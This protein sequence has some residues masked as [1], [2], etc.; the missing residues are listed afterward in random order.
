MTKYSLDSEEILNKISPITPKEKKKTQNWR[1]TEFI[2][3][4][5]N[6]IKSL[7]KEKKNIKKRLKKLSNK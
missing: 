4:I 3:F 7:Q 5:G 2:G 1:D 6:P